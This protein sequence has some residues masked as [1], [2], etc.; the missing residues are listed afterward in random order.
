MAT[1]FSPMKKYHV[2]LVA[3]SWS[4]P[5]PGRPSKKRSM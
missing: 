4:A 2:P 3:A 5:A 1:I